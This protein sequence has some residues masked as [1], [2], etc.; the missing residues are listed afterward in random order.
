MQAVVEKRIKADSYR[1]PKAYTDI[2]V[3]WDLV[4]SQ[5]KTYEL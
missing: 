4:L 3:D 2:Y 1:W 5:L